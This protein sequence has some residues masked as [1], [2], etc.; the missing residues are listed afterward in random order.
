MY[1]CIMNYNTGDD[2]GEW[3]SSNP[4]Q[5]TLGKF[6]LSQNYIFYSEGFDLVTI[7]HGLH[8]LNHRYC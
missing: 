4:A 2:A 1:W 3:C 6:L 8:L 5:L 7:V